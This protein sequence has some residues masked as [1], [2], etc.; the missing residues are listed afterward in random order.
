[1]FG[2]SLTDQFIKAATINNAGNRIGVG[3]KIEPEF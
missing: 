1:M 2:E 3:F